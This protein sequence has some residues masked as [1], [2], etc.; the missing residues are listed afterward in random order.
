MSGT[1][2]A[3]G[4]EPSGAAAEDGVSAAERELFGGRL[5]WDDAFVEHEGSV[6]RLR[7]GQMAAALPRMM[8]VVLRA[9]WETDPRALAGVV[10]V[11]QAGQGLTTAFGLVAINGVL[12][13]LFANGPTDDK[14]RESVPA[15]V[16]LALVSVGMAVLAAWSTALSGRLEPQVER[17]VSLRYY[18][19]VTR[20][21]VAATE[22]P[23]TSN[24]TWRRASSARS[25][26]GACSAC[27][28]G[29]PTS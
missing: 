28:W 22:Q 6:S 4:P 12:G 26:P 23:P 16:L 9:G 21:E 2:G 1:A 25:R 11:A 7:F 27:P 29:P 10:V 15:L 13:S 3:G 24:V 8:G 19:A 17:A 5:R 18:R 20:V 14:L